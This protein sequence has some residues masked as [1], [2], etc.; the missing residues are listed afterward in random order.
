MST[1]GSDWTIAGTTDTVII[2]ARALELTEMINVLELPDIDAKGTVSGTFPVEI[3]GPN[4]Y[5]RNARLTADEQGGTLAYTG[6]VGEQAAKADE[7]VSMAFQ[8]L[9]DFRFSVLELGVDGNL[10]GDM[11]I[12][13]RLVGVSPEVLDGAPFAF[14]IGIDTKLMQLIRTGRSLT[15]SD[16]LA[17]ITAMQQDSTGSDTPAQETSPE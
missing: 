4:A 1:G 9:R 8:A 6:G 3:S 12:T 7:R 10:S 11:L 14:N 16:W 17:D 2:E 13:L 5:I 15:S